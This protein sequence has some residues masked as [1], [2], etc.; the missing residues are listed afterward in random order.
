MIALRW[1]G[2]QDLRLEEV[3][4]PGPPPSGFVNVE[5]SF[6]GICGSDV[7]EYVRGPEMISSKPHPLSGHVPP[8]TLGHEFSGR[9]IAVSEGSEVEIGTRVSADV[10]WRCGKCEYCRAGD[11]HVCRY[12]GSLGFHSDGAFASQVQLPEYML[13]PLPDEVGDEYGAMLEPLAVGLHALDRAGLRAGDDLVIF[14]FG[15]IGAA[16][17][18]CAKA[19][20][21]RALVV[22]LSAERLAK[23]EELGF[24]TLETGA[25]LPRRLRAQL[26]RGGADVVVESTGAAPVLAQAIECA[27]RGG[28]IAM[29]GLP[30]SLSEIDQR[31][32]VL[33]ERSA[34]GALGYRGDLPRVAALLAAGNLN[35]AGIISDIVP[36]GRAVAALDSL[37]ESP[38]S[39]IKVLIQP[40]GD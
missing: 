31:R 19:Q 21:A 9:V 25:D 35:L 20:G 39:K 32:L 30:T 18:L 16:A 8:V 15:P 3:P 23:A 17:A 40:G 22:E 4:E 6:C 11:Y 36:L 34:V 24:A 2:R 5:V 12:G 29:V 1:H 13:V 10:C 33:F 37:I 26:G 7:T 28:R 27:R 38:G 14:G